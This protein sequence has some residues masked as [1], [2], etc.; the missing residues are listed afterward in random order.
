[1]FIVEG[2]LVCPYPRKY[3]FTNLVTLWRLTKQRDD[4]KLIVNP[5]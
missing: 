2:M 1:M 5:I 3:V 4:D